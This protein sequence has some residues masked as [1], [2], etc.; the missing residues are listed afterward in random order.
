M[1]SWRGVVTSS[2]RE[3]LLPLEEVYFSMGIVLLPLKVVLL[4][5]EV[6]SLPLGEV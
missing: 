5:L 4:T 1:R 6:V 2:P 3:V